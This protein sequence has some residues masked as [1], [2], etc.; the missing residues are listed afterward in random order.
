MRSHALLPFL[1][2]P[3]LTACAAQPSPEPAA[4]E[5]VVIDLSDEGKAKRGKINDDKRALDRQIAENAGILGVLRA[6]EGQDLSGIFGSSALGSDVEGAMGGL[7]GNEVGEAYGVGGLGLKGTGRGGGGT[8]EGIGLGSIGTIGKGGGG[9]SGSGRG[10][11]RLG[12]SGKQPP[13]VRMGSVT[14]GVGLDKN[15]IRRIVRSHY[16]A[17]R[18][19]YEKR[20]LQDPKLAGRVAVDFVIGADGSVSGAKAA[21]STGDSKLDDC[22]VKVFEGMVFPKP[23]GG[24]VVQVKYPVVFT[25]GTSK[26]KPAKPA[27]SKGSSGTP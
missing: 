16:G 17:M 22:V 25:P 7:S 4:P 14:T 15:I 18:F 13:R 6:Q 5:P 20:L 24:S 19:C 11:G 1:L 23:K 27:P 21:E 10:S 3:L 8:G 26:S 9:V 12:R 2:I